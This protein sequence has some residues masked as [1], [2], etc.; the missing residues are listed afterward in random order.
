MEDSVTYQAI[1][2]EGEAKGE[3]KGRANEARALLLLLGTKRFGAPAHEIRARINTIS[4]V[5]QLES[6]VARILDA[7]SWESL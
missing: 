7:S 6:L 2:E 4:D 3:A 1:L 5:N